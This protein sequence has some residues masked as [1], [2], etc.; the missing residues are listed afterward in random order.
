MSTPTTHTFPTAAAHF[1]V[2][3]RVLRAAIRA[4]R[5]PVPPVNNATATLPAEWVAA[6]EEALK[7]NPGALNRTEHQKT[8]AFA[9]YPGTSAWR[10]YPARV[11]EFN[12]HR[13]ATA[14]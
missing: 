6:A 7:T 9:R 12:R 4:G 10:K 14:A 3:I 8:P 1:G 2:A 5:L 11:R 13:A